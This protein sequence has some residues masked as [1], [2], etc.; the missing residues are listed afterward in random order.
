VIKGNASYA[1]LHYGI[2]YYRG[3]LCVMLEGSLSQVLHPRCSNLQVKMSPE[4]IH[5]LIPSR[6]STPWRVFNCCMR[7]TSPSNLTICVT[8]PSVNVF[9]KLKTPLAQYVRLVLFIA[10][11]HY[12][13]LATYLWFFR[14][15]SI[16]PLPSIPQ[17]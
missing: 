11:K 14:K 16:T 7:K 8:L 4:V 15:L 5:R 9:V 10:Q 6:R 3:L 13:T 2:I 1:I 17:F 12:V